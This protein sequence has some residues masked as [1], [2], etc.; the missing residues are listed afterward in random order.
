[1]NGDNMSFNPGRADRIAAAKKNVERARD[2]LDTALAEL[3]KAERPE[4]EEPEIGTILTYSYNDGAGVYR[5]IAARTHSGEWAITRW[6]TTNLGT[7]GSFTH[8]WLTSWEKHREVIEGYAEKNQL[9]LFPTVL[10]IG[11]PMSEFTR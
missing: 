6:R 3:A 11:A 7:S 4:V 2:N 9:V 8:Q 1:M 5:V 10:L